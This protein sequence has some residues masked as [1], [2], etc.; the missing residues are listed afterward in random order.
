MAEPEDR[1]AGLSAK[2]RNPTDSLD[3]RGLKCP[4]PA[5]RTEKALAVASATV[6]LV[7]L[8]DDPLAPLDIANVC[9]KGGHAL[10]AVEPIETGGWALRIRTGSTDR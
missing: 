7:V 10:I 9:R 6:D 4:L 3:L 1:T 8:A 5:L 2:G